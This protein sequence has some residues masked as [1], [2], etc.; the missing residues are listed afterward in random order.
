MIGSS[1]ELEPNPA[2]RVGSG[3]GYTMEDAVADIVS[4]SITAG[5][6]RIVIRFLLGDAGVDSIFVAD[7]GTGLTPKQI[8]VAMSMQEPIERRSRAGHFGLGL[9]SA[10]F[11]LADSL[12]VISLT[13][14]APAVGRRWLASKATESAEGDI[15][16]AAACASAL[17]QPWGFDQRTQC[18]IVRWDGLRSFAADADPEV[19]LSLVQAAT[20]RLQHHLGMVFHRFLERDSVTIAID[21]E[22]RGRTDGIGPAV[23]V[24]ALDPFGYPRTG[25]PGYPKTLRTMVGGVAVT[26]ECHIWPGRSQ[27]PQFRLPHAAPDQYQG[28]Y[29]YRGDQLLQA[30]GW[31][32][33]GVP[34]S[35]G[36][37]LARVAIDLDDNLVDSGLFSK[38]PGR[39]GLVPAPEF[40]A[41]LLQ[42]VAEDGTSFQAYIEAA[43]AI[44]NKA[45]DR[46][47]SRAK[48]A[49][50][51]RGLPNNVKRAVERELDT[52]PDRE[53]VDLRWRDFTDDVFF[54][55]DRD[56]HS[57]WLNT[58]YRRVVGGDAKSSFNDAPL[59]KTL[60]FLLVET[61]FHSPWWGQKDR[62]NLEL[63]QRLLTSAAKEQLE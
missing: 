22:E 62:D 57:I 30:G 18:T 1:L 12:T 3:L 44:Y 10:S 20:T 4:N 24:R 54:D 42:A 21:V 46:N 59:V 45:H 19:R 32:D 47:R 55:I 40:G 27:Q 28:L 60:L 31:N 35:A 52:L 51:G 7:D 13:R 48:V 5:A 49:P 23:E 39:T 26:A 6:S 2:A 63:W 11:A 53:G 17:A 34:H 50:I 29:F 16:G 56:G 33:I 43:Q 36:L 25:S 15:V 61:L 58:R 41:A 37:Q 9:K 38:N 8:D 14:Q